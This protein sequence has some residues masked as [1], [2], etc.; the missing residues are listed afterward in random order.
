MILFSVFFCLFWV[1]IHK[2]TQKKAHDK[3]YVYREIISEILGNLNDLCHHSKKG[4]KRFLF[5]LLCKYV[6][7]ML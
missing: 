6:S 7:N 1:R 5:C 4:K 2:I 3:K